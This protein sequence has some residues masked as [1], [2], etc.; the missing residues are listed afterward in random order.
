M[1]LWLNAEPDEAVDVDSSVD[2]DEDRSRSAEERQPDQ[3]TQCKIVNDAYRSRT[4]TRSL[5][6]T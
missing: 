1:S 4:T 2:R 6:V 5:A 3:D